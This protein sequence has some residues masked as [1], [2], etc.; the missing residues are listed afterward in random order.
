MGT[1]RICSVDRCGKPVSGRGWCS[2][3]YQRWMRHGDPTAG[4]AMWGEPLAE[5]K[6]AVASAVPDQCWLWPYGADQ[7][8][9]GSLQINGRM[10]KAHRLA[11][12]MAHGAPASENLDAAHRCGNPQ[13]INPHHLR[14]ATKAVNQADRMEHGTDNRGERHGM[15]KLSNEKAESI[16]AAYAAGQTTLNELGQRHGVDQKTIHRIVLRQSYR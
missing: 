13:C 4:R 16:R 11:C 5:V 8:G 7:H 10:V 9:Y 15:A 3:H 2:A 12:E 14:F 1:Q 6:R